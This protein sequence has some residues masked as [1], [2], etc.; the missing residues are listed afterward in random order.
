M[1]L[2]HIHHL[3]ES[4]CCR[5]D[6]YRLIEISGAD[7][8]K[9]LQGQL[10]CDV[11]KLAIDTHT[12]TSHCDPKG[13]ISALF[14]LY[15][16]S[17]TQF[18]AIMPTDLLP[19]ALDQLKKYAV[20]S[21]VEFR[22]CEQALFATNCFDTAQKREENSTVLTINDRFIAWNVMWQ[23]D[24]EAAL[25]DYADILA[26][27]PLLYKA[28]QFEL[29]PQAVN[30]Q[31]LEQAISFTKGCYI[32][33]ETVARAKYRG[34]NKRAMFNLVGDCD[35]AEFQLDIGGAVELQLGENWKQTGTILSGALL[36]GKLWLQVVLNKEID[37]K[38]RFQYNGIALSVA[39]L[40]Y[41][42]E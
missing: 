39:P 19:E 28:N 18:F 24:S 38:S 32:G 10:T 5:L 34:A 37:P 2:L 30:L 21:K 35:R 25:N 33:Q 14:R 23:T 16:A 26:G 42:I 7:S 41:E 27:N 1:K 13:K 31:M 4:F 29:I 12:L 8:E 11:T 22:E 6:Q 9:Y 36:N 3:S 17:D 40:P 20:F 15:R